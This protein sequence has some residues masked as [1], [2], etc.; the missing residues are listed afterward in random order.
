MLAIL[1]IAA[2][3]VSVQALPAANCNTACPKIY[4]PVCGNNNIT[5]ANQCELQAAA[6]TNNL[7]TLKVASQGECKKQCVTACQEIYKPVCGT[8]KVTYANQCV[9][10][11][12]ACSKNLVNLKVA[13]QGRC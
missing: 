9:L 5:Y 1:L 4:A 7:T 12:T 3:A 6:C 10:E 2:A 13:K 11:A 8:D